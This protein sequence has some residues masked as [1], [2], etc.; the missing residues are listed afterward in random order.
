ME[1]FASQDPRCYS[2]Y[3]DLNIWFRARKVT[4]TFEKRAPVHVSGITYQGIFE[5]ATF[6]FRI[7]IRPSIQQ[8]SGFTPVP[9]TPLGILAKEHASRLPYSRW[10]TGLYLVTSPDKKN[11]RIWSLHDSGFLAYSKISTLESRFKKLRISLQ[12]KLQNYNLLAIKLENLRS[13][14]MI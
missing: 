11:I 1:L 9:R 5:S 14:Q 2:L 8:V 3:F 10:R 12:K 13:F 4:G 7:R 6:P